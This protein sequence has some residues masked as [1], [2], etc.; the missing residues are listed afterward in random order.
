VL[1][2][3]GA[4]AFLRAGSHRRRVGA[5]ETRRVDR[6]LF[7]GEREVE[8]QVMPLEA[9]APLLGAVRRAV[10]RDVIALG[11]ARKAEGLDLAQHQLELDDIHDLAVAGG[12]KR[13]A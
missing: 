1:L 12:G 2:A 10:D 3:E 5:E 7:A 13:G 9:P 8:R 6:H 4:Q 11:I